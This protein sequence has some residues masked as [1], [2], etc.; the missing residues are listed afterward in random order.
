MNE[1]I[2]DMLIIGG[3]PAGLAAAITAARAGKR[4]ILLEKNGFLGGNL[5]HFRQG[6]SGIGLPC[7][8]ITGDASQLALEHLSSITTDDRKA[9]YMAIR[10]LADLGHRKIAVIGG[11]REVSD[12]ARLRNEGCLDACREF[13]IAY[14]PEQDYCTGRFSYADGYHAVKTLLERGRS[15]SAIFAM[16]DV[17]AIGAIRAL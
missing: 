3:G 14:D 4:V 1:H 2:H 8:L 7:V 11:S 16:A 12:I 15:F 6:F 17:M 13:G 10:H 9:G 5:E